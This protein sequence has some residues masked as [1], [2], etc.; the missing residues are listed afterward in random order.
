MSSHTLFFILPFLHDFKMSVCE[1]I[2]KSCR[3]GRMKK[4]QNILQ[5]FENPLHQQD[6]RATA[7]QS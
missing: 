1:L 6:Q 7:A 5:I 2:L 4:S 3:K